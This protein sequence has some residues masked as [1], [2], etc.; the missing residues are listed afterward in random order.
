MIEVIA[1]LSQVWNASV[2]L[3]TITALLI[4]IVAW[5]VRTPW[6]NLTLRLFKAVAA[7]VG[8]TVS[9][10]IEA[11]LVPASKMLVITIGALI[12]HRIIHMPDPYFGIVQN[13]LISICVIAVF[14]I[15]NSSQYL[16]RGTRRAI[17]LWWS[18]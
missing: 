13:A 9:E 16:K 4:P 8:V 12:A 11:N 17:F 7:K 10:Q 14:T 1:E 6:A 5:F 2:A 3:R 15:L 18:V